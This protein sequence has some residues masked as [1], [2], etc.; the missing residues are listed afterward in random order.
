MLINDFQ[1]VCSYPAEVD[2]DFITAQGGFPQPP[3]RTSVLCGFVTVSKVFRFLHEC[4]FHHRC[5]TTGM[6][7]IPT[8][9][10]EKAEERLNRLVGPEMPEALHHPES[11]G[12]NGLGGHSE[13]FGMQRANILITAAIAK[14]ALVRAGSFS[15]TTAYTST[16][17]ARR[18]T[19]SRRTNWRLSGR[20]LPRRFTN[21]S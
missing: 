2:D 14:F 18:S 17:C 16:T 15:L 9:W 12:L 3:G 6:K 20:R 8:K 13:V 4:F 7:T 10:T 19:R 1:G 5:V 11:V 21:V